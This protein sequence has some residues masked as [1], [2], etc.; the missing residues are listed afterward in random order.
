[1]PRDSRNARDNEELS[2]L[3]KKAVLKLYCHDNLGGSTAVSLVAPG[4][5][6]AVHMSEEISRPSLNV[7]RAIVFSILLNGTLGFGMLLAA[8]F[9]LGNIDEVLK[10]PTGY[11]FMAIFHFVATASRMIWF[12]ARDRGIPGWQYSSKIEPR[13]TLPLVSIALTATIAILLSLIGLGSLVA[14]NDVVSLS[15]NRLYTSYLIGNGFLLYRRIKG[16]IQP[17]S[18]IRKTLTPIP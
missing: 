3:G 13:T 18:A 8:L 9:C 11:P 17:Y 10:T 4:A 2:Q 12:F 16:Q 14:F 1:M 15:I 5:N 6:G 7:P